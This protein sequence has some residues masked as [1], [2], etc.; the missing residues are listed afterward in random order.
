[1]DGADLIDLFGPVVYLPVVPVEREAV[2]GNNVYCVKHAMRAQKLNEVGINGR[3]AAQ[4]QR[5]LRIFAADR[6]GR[7]N[8]HLR[9]QFPVRIKLEIPMGKVIGFV[10]KHYC[11]N[12]ARTFAK[13]AGP[14]SYRVPANSWSKIYLPSSLVT[15]EG[16]QI[17]VSCS[18]CAWIS[19]PELR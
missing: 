14:T 7:G 15:W 16:A 2:H 12:H 5:Q 3:D 10:P 18:G 19:R 17:Q 4:H 11:F 6:F 13:M 8:E 1:R 9:E